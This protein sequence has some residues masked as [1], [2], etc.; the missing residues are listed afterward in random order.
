MDHARAHVSILEKTSNK[1]EANTL[2]RAPLRAFG[3]TVF[4][5][6]LLRFYA[7]IICVAPCFAT[8]GVE[9]TQSFVTT[10]VLRQLIPL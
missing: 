4:F 3:V 2:D 5:H 7:V 9:A 10:D 8:R 6:S 1:T